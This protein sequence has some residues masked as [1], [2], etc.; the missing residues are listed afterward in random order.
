MSQVITAIDN[1]SLLD[2]VIQ[3]TGSDN[4]IIEFA[5]VN[6]ISPTEN[7]NAGD[8]IKIP[9]NLE[10]DLNIVQIYKKAGLVPAT[11]PSDGEVN[12]YLTLSCEERFYNCF[13]D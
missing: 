13:K 2:I 6:G 9:G 7:I 5:K 12:Q 10:I 4:D 11:K 1:Q 3:V 8:Q